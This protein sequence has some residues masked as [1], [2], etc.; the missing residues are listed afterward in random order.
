MQDEDISSPNSKA[1]EDWSHPHFKLL[2]VSRTLTVRFTGDERKELTED[3]KLVPNKKQKKAAN[4]STSQSA[5]RPALGAPPAT[6][7]LTAGPT[8][9]GS[10]P[11]AIAAKFL[12]EYPAAAAL[13][14]ASTRLASVVDGG[15]AQLQPQ[16]D[17]NPGPTTSV[18][19][20]MAPTGENSAALGQLQ[21]HS[22]DTV[23]QVCVSML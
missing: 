4:G 13:L 2:V 6:V 1:L 21:P 8:T 9:H 15:S 22:N 3:T 23:P 16:A 19:V 7:F 5:N 17:S 11:A 12:L 14:S 18:F 10:G 20:G